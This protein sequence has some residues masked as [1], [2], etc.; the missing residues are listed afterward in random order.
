MVEP[1]LLD[2]RKCRTVQGFQVDTLHFSP[3]TGTR[4]DH[5][6]RIGVAQGVGLPFRTQIHTTVPDM[7]CL[8][9]KV[10]SQCCG[11]IVST[12][13]ESR[14]VEK[15]EL[16]GRS[17]V[18]SS[19]WAAETSDPTSK[20]QADTFSTVSCDSRRR[21]VVHVRSDWRGSKGRTDCQRRI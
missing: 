20:L 15:C 7:L 3:E 12:S 17:A 8:S 2:A 6:R 5:L 21:Y 18:E 19:E 14:Q 10:L 4:G 1:C 11:S 13:S 16:C 9:M